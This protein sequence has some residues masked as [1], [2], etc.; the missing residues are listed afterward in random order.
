MDV[1]LDVDPGVDDAL[2][3]LMALGSPELSVLGVT[4]VSGNVPVEKG[5]DNALRIL[6]F[7][8]REDV[9]VFIGADRPLK[10][11]RVHAEEVHGESGLGDAVLPEA[12][13]EAETDAVDFL[14]RTLDGREGEVTLVAVGPLTNLA[15]AEG[16]S[17]GILRKAA[18][19]IVMGGTLSEPGNVS[20]TAEFNF[21]ADPAAAQCVI[22]SSANV[23]LI[24]LDVTHRVGL[25][26]ED[27]RGR[28]ADGTSRGMFLEQSTR[29]V[30]DFGRKYGG[31]E[32][33]H[34]H[35]PAA[36]AFVLR[37]DLF[38]VEMIHADVKVDGSQ[39]AGQL[40]ADTRDGIPDSERKGTETRI[41]TSVA[42]DEVLRLFEARVLG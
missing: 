36:V 8:G 1:I 13:R 3:M 27:I 21:F 40:V 19:V 9:P 14:I 29:A 23:T 31:Y 35:D 18:A 37:P 41:T 32:G 39:T 4:L 30:V 42:S 10:R 38:G 33:I 5:T 26:D 12:D 7:A 11:E 24:P 34:L 16:R 2:A 25:P 15:L 6:S 28:L 20:P 17:P 22:R